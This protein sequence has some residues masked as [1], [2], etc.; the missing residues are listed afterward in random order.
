MGYTMAT[1]RDTPSGT[2][3]SFRREDDVGVWTLTDW[4]R[5]FEEEISEAEQHYGQTASEPSLTASVVV[6][7]EVGTLD[8]EMQE[9]ITDAW[10]ELAQ[11][12]DVDRIAYVADGITALAVKSNVE[13]PDTEIDSFESEGAAVAWARDA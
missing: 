9:Y 1:T 7:D 3:W 12:V 10:S 6:F 13:A 2:W 8:A 5:L 4:D 11:S